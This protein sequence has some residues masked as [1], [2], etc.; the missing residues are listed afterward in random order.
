MTDILLYILLAFCVAITVL[1]I[2][3][4]LKKP[5]NTQQIDFFE[6]LEKNLNDE[7]RETRKE[8]NENV[9]N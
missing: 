3:L 6:K 7:L 2:V 8:S 1:L 4:L 9:N 5:N